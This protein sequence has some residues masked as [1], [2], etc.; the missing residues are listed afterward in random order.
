VLT[1]FSS[2][3]EVAPHRQAEIIRRLGSTIM[4]DVEIEDAAKRLVVLA[5]SG[6]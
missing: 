3:G 1:T 2:Y 4:K 6:V 5:R